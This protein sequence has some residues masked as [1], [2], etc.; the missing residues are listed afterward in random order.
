LIRLEKPRG[1]D[2]ICWDPGAF[3][4]LCVEDGDQTLIRQ[5]SLLHDSDGSE[6]MDICVKQVAGGRVSNLLNAD[7]RTGDY[8]TLLGPPISNGGLASPTLPSRALFVAGGVGITPIISHLRMIARS[9]APSRL[10]TSCARA[11]ASSP[12]AGRDE[13]RD[14]VQAGVGLAIRSAAKPRP[15]CVQ[16]ENRGCGSQEEAERAESKCFRADEPGSNKFTNGVN[17]THTALL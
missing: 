7:V 3:V 6:T 1:W 8:L 17:A 16:P 5:Y 4:S 11:V 12:T 15:R 14:E 10:L 2:E 9:A 13:V